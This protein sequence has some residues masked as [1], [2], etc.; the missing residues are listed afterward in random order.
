[1]DFVK[2]NPEWLYDEQYIKMDCPKCEASKKC[3]II[4]PIYPTFNG[5]EATD[6]TD[7]NKITI[8]PSVLH[9]CENRP[10]FYVTNGKVDMLD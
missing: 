1:M 7:F 2:L 4:I 6:T 3:L 9:E 10:H 5:W 8:K